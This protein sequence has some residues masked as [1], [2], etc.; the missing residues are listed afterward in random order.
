MKCGNLKSRFFIYQVYSEFV[1]LIYVYF[2][3]YLFQNNL[4]ILN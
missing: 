2:T 4:Q 1:F 3:S